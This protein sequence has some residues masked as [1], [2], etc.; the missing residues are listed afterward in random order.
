MKSNQFDFTKMFQQFDLQEMTKKMQEAFNFDFSAINEAQSKNLEVMMSTNKAFA[1]GAQAVLEKQ[2]EMF[3]AAMK[4][5]STAAS[6][7]A[8]SGSPQEVATKQAELMK[9]AYETA[10]KNIAEISEMAKKTQDEVS[11]KISARIAE[12]MQ[13]LKDSMAKIS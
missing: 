7:L 11:E 9:V 4:E 2:A 3:Q 12:S 13:E 5:A 8:G 1:D 10:L 6:E